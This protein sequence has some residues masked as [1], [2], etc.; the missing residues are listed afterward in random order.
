[1]FNKNVLVVAELAP[2]NSAIAGAATGTLF[3]L[4]NALRQT[5]TWKPV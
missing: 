1:M 4:I 3:D 5:E 2:K